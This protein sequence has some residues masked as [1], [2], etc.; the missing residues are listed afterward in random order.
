MEGTPTSQPQA[1]QPAQPVAG[2]AMPMKPHRGAAVLVLG[3]LGIVICFICGIIAWI[4]GQGD[5]KK[6]WRRVR[7]ILGGE[8]DIASF[9]CLD[10]RFDDQVLLTRSPSYQLMVRTRKQAKPTDKE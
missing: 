10:L 5:L 1:P 8:E 7:T 3:I 6:K 4:M 9:S 2:Q